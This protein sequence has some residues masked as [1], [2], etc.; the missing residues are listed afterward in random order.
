MFSSLGLFQS[1]PCPYKSS[2]TRTK[3]LFSHKPETQSPSYIIAVPDNPT[4]Q[5]STSSNVPAKRALPALARPSGLSSP[6]TSSSLE[7]PR[8]LQKI[9]SSQKPAA[10]SSAVQ[11]N[12]GVPVLRVNASLSKVSIPVRQALLKTL[13]DHFA[14]LYSVI[15]P[16]NPTLAA[17]HALRQEEE[18]YELSTKL[19]Y[20]TA[21]IQ[22]AASLKRRA[23]PDHPSHDSIGTQGDIAARLEARKSITSLRLTRELL[24]PVLMSMEQLGTWGFMTV[25]PPGPGGEQ[26]SLEGKIATCERCGQ[27]FQVKRMKEADECIYHWGK[28]YSTKINGEKTR[29]YKCCSKQVTDAEGC[30][31]G[32][33]TFYESKPEDLHSRHPFSFLRSS[34]TPVR[35]ILDIV[36]LDC[37]MIS[38][39]GGSRVA[40]VSVVDGAGKEVFDQ[41]VRMDEGVEVIDYL[42]RFSGITEEEHAKAILSLESI[43]KALDSYI[44]SNTI[45]I[46]HALDNDLKTLRIIHHKCVD[47]AILF[48][49]RAGP[50]YRR[51]LR[52]L[53]REHLGKTIQSGGGTVGHS[54]LEDAIATLDLVRWYIV[55]EPKRKPKLKTP[56]TSSMALPSTSSLSAR[57]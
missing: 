46:G 3:C 24:E 25:T 42:T 29:V 26:P 23:L 5:Q 41:L 10:V 9:G 51:A 22:C 47:T 11:V 20:R 33:H 57:P 21:V 36:A 28:P 35:T 55:N 14:V 54:S 6:S 53:V 49:H 4:P 7:P 52:D 1:L 34:S 43:R 30:S 13:Y 40:R 56:L 32:P 17:E 19:T 8:K 37:E 2:C 12:E 39:T 18:I 15:L 45:I 31:R 50:P 48:P 27:P 16:T 44:D 38:T